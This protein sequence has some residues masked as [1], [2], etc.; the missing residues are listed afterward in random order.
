MSN[1]AENWA[2]CRAILGKSILCFALTVVVSNRVCVAVDG[3]KPVPKV[4]PGELGRFVNPFIGTGG[5]SYLCGNNFPGA[6]R[7]F[8]KVRLSPDTVSTLGKRA[9]NTSGYFYSD[10]RILGFS[11]TRLAGTGA[12]DGGN[13][14]VIPAEKST[15]RTC[16]RGMNAA[17]L[18]ENETAFPGYYGLTFPKLG[19]R[20]ELTAMRHT[21]FHRYT[22]D[23]NQAP[24][25]VIDVTSVLGK[26]TS[27]AGEVRVVPDSNE[28]EGTVR[29]FGTFA[30]RYGGLQTYF[31]ARFS[32][33]FQ[34][35][36]TWIG[37]TEAVGQRAAAGNDLCA[38]LG[39]SHERNAQVV[40]L[41]LAISYVSVANA[42]ENL[43]QEA[44]AF[45]F[46]QALAGA[47]EEWEQHLARIRVI[48]GTERQRTIFYTALYHS[49]QMPTEFND[50]NGEYIGFDRQTHR[51]MKARYYT[52]MSLW[53]TFRTVHPLFNLIARREQRDMLISL[54]TMAE[55]G[56]YL[57]RWPSGGG[58]TGSMFG[59]PA[60]IVITE[61]YL[62]GIRGFDVETAFQFMKKTALGPV[63]PGAPFSGRVGIEHYLKHK[64]CPAD[65]MKKSVASTVEYSYA[66]HAIA[67][68]AHELGH[69]ED[70]KQFDEHAAYYRN[71]F[72]PETQ[73]FQPR[74]ANG[75]FSNAFQPELLT[76]LDFG[77]T[78]THGYV[79]GSA[80][81]WRWG[82]PSDAAATIQL[83]R[84]REYFVQELEK[85]FEQSPLE[86]AVNPNAYYW[87]GNQPDIYA[88]FLFN[89]AGRPDLTQKW[90]RWIMDHKYGDRENGVD[91]NDD[92]GTLS[93]WYV[94]SSIGL[95]PTAGTDTYEITSPLWDQAQ[96][97]IGDQLL[98][99]TVERQAPEHLYVK[100][101]WLN[102][103]LVTQ[104]SIRHSQ[105]ASGGT[106]RFEMGPEPVIQ[107]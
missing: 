30:K 63:P 72:N 64:Y 90:S 68:L 56:G 85:F 47:A 95:F 84:S 88:A 57:P 82:V 83:F 100:R 29:T 1:R 8:G 91:G 61:S 50:V 86:L 4:L 44:A 42:R 52:D 11:H 26:G 23:A 89:V 39:F 51:A 67:R 103:E 41:K 60:D 45:D 62:K 32:R 106:L 34:E 81:Q 2:R 9:S 49:L 40:E 53:D 78:Q 69:H 77:G 66:D 105:I 107:P 79:E 76:Y 59:S 71:V 46:D 31:V 99:V 48:G 5:I 13:F 102:D 16:R 35:F 19:I 73:F 97:A 17:F 74:E 92:G 18:H 80:W 65:L 21:G 10:N 15:V 33:P 6:T 22:F 58:Y 28:V 36:S 12:T 55:Q 104:H 20:A 75:Q 27:E 38:T 43:D 93:A 24:Q 96:I 87:H 14:L 98:V 7:P 101:L 54:V 94:L 25:I 3:E 37:D 70:G